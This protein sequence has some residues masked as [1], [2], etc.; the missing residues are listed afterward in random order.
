M[1]IPRLEITHRRASGAKARRTAALELASA[2][3]AG[4]SGSLIMAGISYVFTIARVA[5]ML[6]EDEDWLH[7]ICNEMDPE[8]GRLTVLGPDDEAITAFTRFGVDNLTELVEMYKSR[9][10]PAPALPA[11]RVTPPRSSPDADVKACRSPP[12]PYTTP[13]PGRVAR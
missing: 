6:G 3:G 9:P 5:K 8:D 7:E 11:T 12:A 10:R 13:P 1:N 4:Q 2:Q